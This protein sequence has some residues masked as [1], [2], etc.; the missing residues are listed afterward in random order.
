VLARTKRKQS[1]DV[2]GC[3]QRYREKMNLEKL[4]SDS[5]SLFMSKMS[6]KSI[7]FFLPL[8][9][10]VVVLCCFDLEIPQQIFIS[11]HF[12]V[13]KSYF[14]RVQRNSRERKI[15]Y[16]FVLR[17]DDPL[18]TTRRFHTVLVEFSFL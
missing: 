9:S 17:C 18:H 16:D 10:I 15:R 2:C 4:E 14:L 5:M 3:F 13:V 8:V 11:Q 6:L 7:V 12:C 1:N